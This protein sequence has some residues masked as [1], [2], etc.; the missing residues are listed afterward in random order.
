MIDDQD[1]IRVIYEHQKKVSYSNICELFDLN[2][3][4]I[5]RLIPF[6]PLIKDD[7]IAVKDSLK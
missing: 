5:Y 4:K 3:K 6:L 7:Y 1:Q 2:F